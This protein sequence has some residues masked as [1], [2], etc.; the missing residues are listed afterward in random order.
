M[1]VTRYK[2]HNET[3]NLPAYVDPDENDSPRVASNGRV[4]HVDVQPHGGQHVDDA[5]KHCEDMRAT[6]AR[7]QS[8]RNMSG[9]NA[10]GSRTNSDSPEQRAA[11]DAAAHMLRDS[12]DLKGWRIPGTQTAKHGQTRVHLVSLAMGRRGNDTMEAARNDTKAHM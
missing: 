3:A 7:L 5:S 1:P 11:R 4:S 9:K 6:T 2:T 10:R 12:P 8:F